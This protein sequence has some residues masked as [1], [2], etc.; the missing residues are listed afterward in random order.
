M[1]S[2]PSAPFRLGFDT[3]IRGSS[4]FTVMPSVVAWAG[5]VAYG[6]AAT[7]P[8]VALAPAVATA[9]GVAVPPTPPRGERS[10]AARIVAAAAALPAIRVTRRASSRRVM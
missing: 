10:Q 4:G 8:A 2:A 9:P 5:G 1:R 3:L 7:K 6:P